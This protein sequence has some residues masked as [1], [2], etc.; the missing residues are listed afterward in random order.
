MLAHSPPLPL[1][2]DFFEEGHDLAL[3]DEANILLAF[4]HRDRVRRIRFVMDS[5]NADTLITTIDDEFPT[6]EYLFVF[7]VDMTRGNGTSLMRL[8]AFRAPRLRRLVLWGVS[9]HVGTLLTTTT[10]GLVTLF[11]DNIPPSAYFPPNDLVLWLSLLPHLEILG[12]I[13]FSPTPNDVVD[14]QLLQMPTMTHVTHRNLRWFMFN[15]T[16]TYLEGVLPHIT[17][18][19]LE[20]FQILF[21][22][23]RTTF[24]PHLRQFVGATDKLRYK[25]ARVRFKENVVSMGMYPHGWDQMDPFHIGVVCVPLDRQVASLAQI[26]N[27]VGTAFSEV[28]HLT[29]ECAREPKP[30]DSSDHWQADRARWLEILGPFGNVKTLGVSKGLTAGLSRSLRFDEGESPMGFLPELKELEYDKSDV[31]GDAFAAFLHA[32]Q[33]A[34][35]PVSLAH[36]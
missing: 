16:S 24:V 28:E 17:T 11:L 12:I 29:L 13:F 20:R 2:I 22:D 1:I 31:V 9:V 36:L 21:F 18:P 33:N 30:H 15:G 8:N 5:S 27:A 19:L 6:L 34:G 23:Q 14:G 10:C 26:S 4:R 7:Q 25:R 32:R 3:E 35:H